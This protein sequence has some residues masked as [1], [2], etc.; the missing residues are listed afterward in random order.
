MLYFGELVSYL[1]SLVPVEAELRSSNI[2]E[3]ER[4]RER[5]KDNELRLTKITKLP[6]TGLANF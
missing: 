4:E 6:V 5:K 3:R 2:A 1:F